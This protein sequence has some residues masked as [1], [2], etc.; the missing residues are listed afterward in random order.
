MPERVIVFLDY[1]NVYQGARSAFHAFGA[2]YWHGQ[3]DPVRLSVRLA[4]DSPFDRELIQVRVYRG[5]PDSK[6]DPK[7]YGA[8]RRQH[9][10]WSR[11]PSMSLTTRP[12]RYPAGWPSES[13]EGEKPVE[14]GIDVQI[15]LDYVLMAERGQYDVGI[16]MSTDTDLKPAL[17]EVASMAGTRSRPPRPEVAAWS[18][19]GRHNRRLSIK[20]AANLWCHWLDKAAY[21]DVKD[22]TDYALP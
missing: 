2:P 5:Q 13:L 14:K 20:G 3:V 12:L 22:E 9:A 15:A 19:D 11:S 10:V 18:A 16:L 6:R 1:Q 21:Q 8:S 4:A 7:G 17:E